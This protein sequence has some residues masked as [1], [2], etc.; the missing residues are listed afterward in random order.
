MILV[1]VED[2]KH[3]AA[4][5]CSRAGAVIAEEFAVAVASARPQHIPLLISDHPKLSFA[6]AARA[7]REAPPLGVDPRQAD[8]QQAASTQGRAHPT[9]VIHSSVVLG[10][11]VYVEAR[12]VIG[13]RAQVGANTRV[14]AEARSARA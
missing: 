3:L 10:P 9:A 13:E 6:R 2:E 1:F 14:G 7:L 4:A 11:G 5:L 8:P 12:A